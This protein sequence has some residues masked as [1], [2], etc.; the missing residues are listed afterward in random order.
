MLSGRSA[1]TSLEHDEKHDEPITVTV[2][3]STTPV[4]SFPLK[5]LFC[6]VVTV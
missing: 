4:M 5:A 2:L 6:T 1:D 3:G